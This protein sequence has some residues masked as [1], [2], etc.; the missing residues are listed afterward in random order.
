MD[1]NGTYHGLS[2]EELSRHCR[3]AGA[4]WSLWTVTWLP[5][6]LE[7]RTRIF[8]DLDPAE[9]GSVGQ[10]VDRWHEGAVST[11]Q[12]SSFREWLN[13]VVDEIRNGAYKFGCT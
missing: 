7:C 2:R 4:L 6:F 5:E 3:E 12:A 10:I 8:I 1:V 13:E 11:F 9:G